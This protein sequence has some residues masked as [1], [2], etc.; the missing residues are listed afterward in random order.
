MRTAT[1]VSTDT[2]ID[3]PIRITVHGLFSSLMDTNQIEEKG[4]FGCPWS[5]TVISG[6]GIAG[7][8]SGTFHQK[9]QKS[10]N[11]NKNKTKTTT[12]NALSVLVVPTAEVLTDE[13][14]TDKYAL[15]KDPFQAVR[16]IYVGF[17]DFRALLEIQG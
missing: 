15:L 8:E 6:G 9:D 14:A 4:R 12:D 17:S 16:C 11:I 5:I 3:T 2:P 7:G 1:S 10:Q 13:D